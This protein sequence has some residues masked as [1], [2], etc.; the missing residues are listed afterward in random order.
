M[1]TTLNKVF[2]SKI[3]KS[4]TVLV[5]VALLFEF[6]IFPGLTAADTIINIAC[7]LL[8]L[9]TFVYLYYF[10][11]IDSLIHKDIEVSLEPGETE[12]DYF[13]PTEAKVVVRK[14]RGTN[15]TET[16]K[17]KII[18]NIKNK[19]LYTEPKNSNK[20]TTTKTTTKS[21]KQLKTKNND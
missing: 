20:K 18:D 5:I 2:G 12:L 9:I 13:P 19:G 16:E 10:F 1:K 11:K 4:L 17:K 7:G 21:K 3:I 15:L 8:A 14:K 6:I